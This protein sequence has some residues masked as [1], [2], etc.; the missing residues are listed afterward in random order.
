[1]LIHQPDD[2]RRYMRLLWL[3]PLGADCTE[4]RKFNALSAPVPDGLTKVDSGF[5]MHDLPVHLDGRDRHALETFWNSSRCQAFLAEQQEKIHRVL[6]SD[7][8]SS[9]P[10]YPLLS[11]WFMPEA[12][13]EAND[14]LVQALREEGLL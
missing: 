4:H 1:M 10:E 7:M 3:L 2:L 12:I 13:R 11:R 5:R 6:S 14:R 9:M 8:I